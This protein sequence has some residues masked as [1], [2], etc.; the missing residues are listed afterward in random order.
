MRA[1]VEEGVKEQALLAPQQG[2]GRD[3]KGNPVAWVVDKDDKVVRRALELDRTIGDN[4]SLPR[5]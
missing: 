5:G 2:V 1:V 4:G 3:V